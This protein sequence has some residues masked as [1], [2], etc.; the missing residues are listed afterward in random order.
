MTDPVTQKGA[1]TDSSQ[2]S[3]IEKT[4]VAA[5]HALDTARDGA[6]DVADRTVQVIEANPLPMLI[7]G[8]AVGALA[9]ALLPRSNREAALL[10]P[11]GRKLRTTTTDAVHNAKTTGLAE[12]GA[13]GLSKGALSE[14]G[15]KLVGGILTA[16]VTA[17]TAAMTA[18]KEAKAKSDASA[19]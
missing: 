7:G 15:G 8:M 14:Q 6:R 9:G 5:V 17:G 16:L 10:A 11:V 4:R 12:L 1:N 18:S 2:Q 13:L 3:T 19:E